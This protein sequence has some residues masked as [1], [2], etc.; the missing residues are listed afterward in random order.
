MENLFDSQ[1]K[2]RLLKLFLRNPGRYFPQKEIIRK[3]QPNM[4][5]VSRQLGN[6]LKIGFIKH[7]LM[8]QSKIA[9][10]GIHLSVNPDFEFYQ[11]LRSLVLKSSPTS[12][13]KILK[14]VQALGSI[15]MILLA[16]IFLNSENSRV[17][18]FIV[19]DHVK[20]RKLRS[21]LRELELEVGKEIEFALLS[22]KE[23]YY[24]YQMFDRFVHDI[25]EK[26]NEKLVNK[27]KV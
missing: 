16:G 26:P 22:T 4:A 2:V 13:E 5:Q 14:K 23:F 9:E 19:G 15:K 3:N 11:E 12:K 6:L 8:R 1:T 25:L 7:K 20:E 21:Y 24:R 17:D 10:A 18:L 27:L